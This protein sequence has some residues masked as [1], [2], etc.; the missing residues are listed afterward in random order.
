MEDAEDS[1]AGPPQRTCFAELGFKT[2]P[3]VGNTEKEKATKSMF[4]K[5]QMHGQE[6][7]RKCK[8]RKH[9]GQSFHKPG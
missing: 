3:T 4:E 1:A 9:V 5:S 8:R 2:Q 7:K 6:N